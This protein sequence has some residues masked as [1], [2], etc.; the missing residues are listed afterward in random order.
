[1]MSARAGVVGL[2]QM[3]SAMARRL[4]RQGEPL[5]VFNR[6]A[7][8][9]AELEALGAHAAASLAA[10]GEHC[11]LIFTVLPDG[12]DVEAVVTGPGGLLAR[13]RPG[14]LFIECSTIDPV[15]TERVAAAV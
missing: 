8:A 2:G 7:G 9:V 15:V 12:P 14:T 6:S 11:D 1:M 3:G 13:A 4:V 5:W 10:L